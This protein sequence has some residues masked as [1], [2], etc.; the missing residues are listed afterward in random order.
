MKVIQVSVVAGLLALAST[1]VFASDVAT[2]NGQGIGQAMLDEN[3]K[4]NVAQGQ[5]DTPELRKTLTEELINRLLLVQSAEKSGLTSTTEARVSVEQLKENFEA[6]LALNAYLSKHPVTDADIR[7]DYDRQVAALGGSKAQQINLSMM[8]LKTKIEAQDVIDQ[9]KKKGND[10]DA[11]AK[12][13][14][15]APSK[16]QGGLVGWVLPAQ[17]PPEL[18]QATAG[19]KKGGIT[20]TPVEVQGAWYVLKVNDTRSFKVPS[21]EESKERIRAALTQQ[22]RMEQ[23]K[24]L[25][26]AAKIN[27]TNAQN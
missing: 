13:R 27:V 24:A 21:F 22:R 19:L 14:S 18:N 6:G 4:A 11:I 23:I 7:A 25:R 5:K 17:L 15:I 2:V 9:L 20:P 3:V 1:T 16:A 10:F 26:D 8:V 12:E